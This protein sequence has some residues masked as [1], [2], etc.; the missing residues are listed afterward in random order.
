MSYYVPGTPSSIDSMYATALRRIA[1]DSR[2]RQDTVRHSV[3]TAV[4]T[5]A[6]V[7]AN[8]E[9][10]V[11]KPGVLLD[12]TNVG[13]NSTGGGQYV[14]VALRK[15]LRYKAIYGTNPQLG[16]EDESML[17]RAKLFYNEI[18]KSIKF[19]QFGYYYNDTE[20]LKF[21]E[22]YDSALALFHAEN[23]DTRYQVALMLTYA[24]EL[25]AAPVSLGQQFNKNWFI[26]NR[27]ASGFPSWDLMALDVTTG[28][29]DADGFY[30]SQNYSGAGTFVEN[31]AASMLAA[32]GTG[33][34]PN[35]ILNVDNLTYMRTHVIDEHMLNMITLDGRPSLILKIPPQVHGWMVNPNNTGSLGEYWENVSGYMDPKQRMIIPGE[36]GRLFETFVVVEDPRCPTLTVG[37]S[38]GSYTLTPGYIQPGNNDDRNKTAWSATSGSANYVFDMCCILGANALGKYTRDD[39][40]TN[41]AESTEYGQVQGRGTYKGEGVQLVAYDKDTAGQDDGANT[42]QIQR[43]ACLVPVSR[44][45]IATLLT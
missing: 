44:R 43:G 19:S 36:I 16:H 33:A 14:T 12:V 2:L 18:K 23:D 21:V 17:L 26:P 20:Y 30:S 6:K 35:A 22:G 41:L 39:L 45:P 40:K 29:A 9:V 34:T 28:A 8:G 1:W 7:G 11:L 15:P 4:K 24:D 25:T 3:F 10:E 27:V 5:D 38:Q 13:K 37:G 31:I 42:T 32:S